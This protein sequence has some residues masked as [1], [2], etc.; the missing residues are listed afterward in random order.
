LEAR[1]GKIENVSEVE[2]AI[3]IALKDYN[4]DKINNLRKLLEEYK[5]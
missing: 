4:V 1:N 5:Y 3:D 2:Y